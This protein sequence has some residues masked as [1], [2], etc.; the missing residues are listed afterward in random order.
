MQRTRFCTFNIYAFAQ[1][2]IT[3]KEKKPGEK[4]LK[5]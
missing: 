2:Q 5:F 3:S 1:I 4:N